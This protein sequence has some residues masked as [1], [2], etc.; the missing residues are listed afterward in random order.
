VLAFR[1]RLLLWLVITRFS[2][3]RLS[4]YGVLQEDEI[5]VYAGDITIHVFSYCVR[6][7]PQTA[8]RQYLHT[9]CPNHNEDAPVGIQDPGWVTN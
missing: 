7:V 2:V 3:R 8:C 1:P 6:V 5:S 9:S 4:Q